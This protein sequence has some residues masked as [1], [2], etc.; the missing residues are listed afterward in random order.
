M[1]T[2]A[3][4]RQSNGRYRV[5]Y[6]YWDVSGH[7]QRG[8]MRFTTRA[9]AEAFYSQRVLEYKQ[10]KVVGFKEPTHL[11]VAQFFT[12][13]YQPY[14][15]NNK[16]SW[17]VEKYTLKIFLAKFGPQKMSDVSAFDIER[18][19]LELQTRVDP[20]TIVRY[21]S[22]IRSFF[23]FAHV[24]M[25][26]ENGQKVGGGFIN[27]N[28]AANVPYPKIRQATKPPTILTPDEITALRPDGTRGAD[29]ALFALYSG[30]RRGEIL[31]LR[32]SDI[33]RVAG[34]IYIPQTKNDT[35]RTL[36]LHPI[37]AEIIDR[38]PKDAGG[39]YV[40]GWKGKAARQCK[41]SFRCLKKRLGITRRL[42]FHD[43]RHT[44]GSYLA[45]NGVDI[46][47]RMALMGHKSYAAARIYTHYYTEKLR[48]S[49]DRLTK[50]FDAARSKS[51]GHE[52]GTIPP[53]AKSAAA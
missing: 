15:E 16:R 30:M 44:F 18:W 2:R 32:H 11:T 37:L 31:R 23:K 25:K 7:R 36:P 5:N 51:K 10:G 40:F 1:G 46:D 12:S 4:R 6:Y 14:V 49:L 29:L 39:D 28:P 43:L 9:E 33:D 21:L 41:S 26:D 22:A 13:Y 17:P 20:A 24:G 47:E 42:R 19:K 34:V 27:H 38:Q 45:M 8:R 3:I 52:K 35:P 48:D 50:A 53:I